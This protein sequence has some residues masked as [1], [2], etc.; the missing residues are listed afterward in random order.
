MGSST[1]KEDSDEIGLDES[2]VHDLK[3]NT[4]FKSKEIREWHEKFQKDFPSGYI[5]RHEFRKLYSDLTAKV[6]V[7]NLH[8]FVIFVYR[9]YQFLPIKMHFLFSMI[10]IISVENG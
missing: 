4:H 2:F 1:S 5:R 3:E 6:R 8:I 7:C 10:L 9:L